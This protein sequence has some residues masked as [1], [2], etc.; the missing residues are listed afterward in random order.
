MSWTM[1]VRQRPKLFWKA[2]GLLLP[3]GRSN[4]IQL[5]VLLLLMQLRRIGENGV[6]QLSLK[7]VGKMEKKYTVEVV[8]DITVVRY[9]N[10]PELDDLRRSIDEA[11]AIR[12]SGLRLWD[13][14]Q[15]GLNLAVPELAEIA[16]YAKTKFSSPSKVAI[17]A[18]K[19][20]S[21]GTSRIY[22]A[23]RQQEGMELEIFRS[24]QKAMEW[25]ET[26]SE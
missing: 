11:A 19:D 12:P 2:V 7:K 9:I 1:L 10:H 8:G 17:V 20:L 16:N 18:P 14:S 5:F 4:K 24:E 22:E 15:G 25:L 26:K 13:F 3:K 23:I 21:F 6:G